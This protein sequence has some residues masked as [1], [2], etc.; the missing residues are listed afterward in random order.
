MTV[1]VMP[2]FGTRPEAIKLAPVIK[3]LER[4]PDEFELV[5]TV[6]AQHRQMLDQVLRLFDITPDHDLDVMRPEQTV[7]EVTSRVLLGLE[8]VLRREQPDVVL[9][10]GDTTTVMAAALAAYYLKI[11][12]AHVE[13][14][15]RSFDKFQPFPEEINRRLVS[16]IGDWH[17][18]PTEGA[19]QNLLREGLPDARIVVTGNTVIDALLATV[20]ADYRFEHPVLSQLDFAGRRVILATTHRRENWGGPLREICHAIRAIVEGHADVDVIYAVH[21]NPQVQRV[22]RAELGDMPRVHLLEPLDYE[23][24]VQLMSRCHLILTDSGGIQEEA[25]S[26]G[27]PVLVLRNVT[28]RPE[29]AE[30]GTLKLVGTERDVIVR[31]AERLLSDPAEYRRMAGASNPYGDGQASR[32][33]ADVLTQLK[34]P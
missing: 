16:H 24:F 29:G 18:P 11:P 31:E 22:V 7:F 1:K 33:I 4:R 25:P 14:G 9:V 26:L 34:R 10:Q 8:P 19:R 32:R 30:A 20:R 2:I 12:V 6:T 5:I 17:F 13:A 21:L 15:L 27:K 23:P 3:E 28:E